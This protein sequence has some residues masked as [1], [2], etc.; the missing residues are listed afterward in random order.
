MRHAVNT[1]ITQGGSR[2]ANRKERPA[3][4]KPTKTKRDNKPAWPVERHSGE[5]SASALETLRKLE[6]RDDLQRPRDPKHSG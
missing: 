2:L 5:G 1:G 6:T 3:T 4:G